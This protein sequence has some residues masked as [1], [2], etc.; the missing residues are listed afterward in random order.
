[1]DRRGM[2][3]QKLVTGLPGTEI[4]EEFRRLVRE[5]KVGNVILFKR[6]VES[7]PQLRR[8]CDE[9]QELVQRETGLP[10]FITIDQEGGM[11]N[12]LCA[13]IAL[14]PGAMALAAT[15]DPKNA[16]DAGFL[17]GRELRR[18]G[19]NFNLS[20]VMD[21]NN[22]PLN[23]VIGAR[24]YGDD[25]ALVAR[26]GCEMV[27]GLQDAGVY[28]CLKHFPGHGDT[29]VDSHL[30][31][32][33]IDKSPD[34]LRQCELM[35]FAE[36]IRAGVRG[37]MTTHILFP[38]IEKG[39]VPATM[40]RTILQDILR[41]E[42]G[43]DGLILSDCMMMQAIAARY[44]TVAGCCAAAK[45]GVDL[46][47][48]CH[49][50]ALTAE[51][52][53]AIDQTLPEEELIASYRRIA[54]A[55]AAL[56]AP[57]AF[58]AEENAGFQATVRRLCDLSVTRADTLGGG[59][60]DPGNAPLFI[61]CRSMGGSPVFNQ[62]NDSAFLPEM[63]RA[64]LGGDAL[65]LPNDPDEGDIARVLSMLNGHSAI[66]ISTFNAHAHVQQQRLIRAVYDAARAPVILAALR[67]P[68]DLSGWTDKVYCLAAYDCT[69]D[70]LVSVCRVL[71][72]EIKPTGTL[73]VRI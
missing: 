57:A 47:F 64:R 48:I 2:I 28:A 43:F 41:G 59:L 27:R 6:N 69:E 46:I 15:K 22:N 56:P 44:G 9:V 70:A 53:E 17:C 29:A 13:P 14:I 25:P 68:Y 20:P 32:P 73:P 30:G 55:K 34:E 66:V 67:N 26:F 7:I 5:H 24:S 54:D 35:P 72:G 18:C 71:T 11:V 4:T 3:G 19:V 62:Q 33:C 60:P 36:G 21:V 37:V 40:S 16:Y 23:P 45:A 58:S 61:G 8:L 12:R 49:D 63:L 10:A 1:M 31:L 38:Q 51:A 39:G 65:N 42:L 52:C 50:N